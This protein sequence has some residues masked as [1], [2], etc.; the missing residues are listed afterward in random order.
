[1]SLRHISLR[2]GLFLRLPFLDRQ[3]ER[4]RLE[5]ALKAQQGTLCCLYGRRR[6]G[7]SRLLQ[8]VLSNRRSVYYLA[9]ERTQDV[10]RPAMARA[11]GDLLPGF[12]EVEYPDW[13]SLLLRWW[14]EAPQGSILALDEFPYLVKASPELPSLLQKSVDQNRER[15]VH[16]LLCGSS[17]RMMQGL[18]LDASAPLYGRAQEVL[19]IGPLPAG[20]IGKALSLE[21]PVEMMQAYAVWGGVP[22][23][24][25]LAADQPSTWDAVEQLVLEPLGILYEEPRRLLLDD[26][27]E[28]AQAS[29]I[30]SLIGAGCHRLSEIA[31]RLGKPATSLT[32]PL[33]RLQEL[34]LARR[35][36]PFGASQRSSRKSLYKIDDPFLAFWF[37]FV[38]PNR[39]RLEAGAVG[40]VKALIREQF[41][42]HLGIVWEDLVKQSLVHL[43]L[44][45][46]MWMPGARWWGAGLDRKHLEVDLLAESAD[47]KTLLIGEVKLSLRAEEMQEVEQQLQ[48]KA[49]RLPFR[50]RFR[51]VLARVFPLTELPAGTAAAVSARDVFESLK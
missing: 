7:K 6:C 23:Y 41:Q 10:Q 47:G 31:A 22:R 43:E 20:W 39:S 25:E 46:Q 45:G 3:N 32:R 24:W 26:L 8:E 40:Q 12:A 42:M 14:R 15:R 1:M 2:E 48:A 4:L 50:S 13:E 44:D 9:D 34:G 11:I 29:S 19:R 16:L 35:E 28:T 49:E 27:R 51:Q 36:L 38:E 17:Q 18:I 33:A 37:R 30:L 21:R 5:R